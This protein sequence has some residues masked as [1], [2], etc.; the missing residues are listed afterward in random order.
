MKESRYYAVLIVGA[1][2]LL[3]MAGIVAVQNHNELAESRAALERSEEIDR[4]FKR[5]MENVG[6][7]EQLVRDIQI[8]TI[9]ARIKVL[10]RQLDSHVCCCCAPD[11]D[12]SLNATFNNEDPSRWLVPNSEE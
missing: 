4:D 10:E 1:L 2:A 8:Q 7:V 5:T 3:L 6:R 12:A 11:D 9:H